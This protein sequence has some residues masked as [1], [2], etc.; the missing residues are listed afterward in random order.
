MLDLETD[1]W[2]AT[3]TN[4]L[5]ANFLQ[6]LV[7]RYHFS[8]WRI[9]V[10][11]TLPGPLDLI[12]AA[13]SVHQCHWKS[14]NFLW[15]EQNVVLNSNL[16]DITSKLR[17]VEPWGCM[18]LNQGCVMCLRTQHENN[19]NTTFALP[20]GVFYKS[21]RSRPATSAAIDWLKLFEQSWDRLSHIRW[22]SSSQSLAAET[23]NRLGGLLQ[24]TPL[25]VL[26]FNLYYIHLC[27]LHF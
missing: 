15:W 12:G 26:G 3:H 17:G 10:T 25:P 16:V 2:W 1:R 21:P 20:E 9:F 19:I 5:S 14:D 7:D 22:Q 27:L 23:V 8:Q 13:S 11:G 18:Q 24:N 6:Q 4:I